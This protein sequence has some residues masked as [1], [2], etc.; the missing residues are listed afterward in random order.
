MRLIIHIGSHKTGTSSI[1]A[2]FEKNYIYFLN[3]GILYPQSC[4]GKI[5][6]K[7]NPTAI[8]GHR[9]FSSVLTR[10]ASAEAANIIKGIKAEIDEKEINTVI[11]SSETFFAPKFK[12]HPSSYEFFDDVKIVCYLRNPFSFLDS[13]Y[14]EKLCWN[15]RNETRFFQNYVIQ[16]GKYWVNYKGKLDD[17]GGAF[18]RENV[19]VRSY[20]DLPR[21]D[22]ISDFLNVC[23]IGFDYSMVRSLPKGNPSLPRHLVP[24]M[25]RVNSQQLSPASKAKF[26]N[27]LFDEL[28]NTSSTC[29]SN[30]LQSLELDRLSRFLHDEISSIITQYNVSPCSNLIANLQQKQKCVTEPDLADGNGISNP[31]IRG[32][33]QE[34]VEATNNSRWGITALSN[35]V[36]DVV[37]RFVNYHRSLGAS[38]IVIFLDKDNDEI[39]TKFE[40]NSDVVCIYCS[41]EFWLEHLG[42]L[43][44]DNKTKLVTCHRVG[45]NILFNKFNLD[46]AVNLDLDELLYSNQIN[47]SDFLSLV[48][49]TVDACTVA[50]AEAVYMRGEEVQPFSAS[51][52]KM[53]LNVRGKSEIEYVPPEGHRLFSSLF[54]RRKIFKVLL[55]RRKIFK[56]LRKISVAGRRVLSIVR[57]I[58]TRLFR[59]E[60]TLL[61]TALKSFWHRSNRPM[62]VEVSQTRPETLI[63]GPESSLKD[64]S[65]VAWLPAMFGLVS[66]DGKPVRVHDSNIWGSVSD[67]YLHCSRNGFFGHL[68]GRMFIRNSDKFDLFGSHRHRSSTVKLAVMPMSND[69]LVLH[70]DAQDTELWIQKWYRR[71]FGDTNA[72]AIS[73]QRKSYQE[74]FKKAYLNGSAAELYDQLHRLDGEVIEKFLKSG[75]IAKINHYL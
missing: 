61:L 71:V 30:P 72:L 55:N 53:N 51:L 34:H 40:N 60:I 27:D 24:L 63:D 70:F 43:P 62:N 33:Y 21:G 16:E 35:E 4:L 22:V 73:E 29:V 68:N 38:K 74:E 65:E 7:S 66:L 12:P 75:H 25:L 37:L 50:S 42:H 26:T 15:G 23:N 31:S 10:P 3:K 17:F 52:F 49:D 32:V 19:C 9:G 59:G 67:Y 46:W 48:P 13:L 11:V 28:Q 54:N 45:F 6:Y 5:K 56:V 1:Q 14:R 58:L 39:R 2:L 57:W 47:V 44:P 18:G 20:D 41:D 64:R 8:A 36:T 69:F